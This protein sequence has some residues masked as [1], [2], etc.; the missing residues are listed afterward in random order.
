VELRPFVSHPKK[1]HMM[2]PLFFL[3]GEQI[4]VLVVLQALEVMMLS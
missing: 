3:A 4:L 1:M 2:L